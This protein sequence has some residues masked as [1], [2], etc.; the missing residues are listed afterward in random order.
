V[1][2][3][4]P[5]FGAELETGACPELLPPDGA[6]VVGVLGGADGW[7]VVVTTWTG[8]GLADRV[9]TTGVAVTVGD[10]ATGRCVVTACVTA[11]EIV[12]RCLGFWTR[13]DRCEAA[14]LR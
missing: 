14:L 10:D 1:D 8:E 5:V 3:E 2:P 4:L 7:G 13:A 11:C 12:A 9:V 6:G